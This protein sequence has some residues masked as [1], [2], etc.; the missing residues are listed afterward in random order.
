M[1]KSLAESVLRTLTAFKQSR[2]QVKVLRPH[3]LH[4]LVLPIGNRVRRLQPCK[5][6]STFI[7]ERTWADALVTQPAF[8]G[9]WQLLRA[10]RRATQR[11]G[12]LALVTDLGGNLSMTWLV[13]PD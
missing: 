5:H 4:S 1:C 11:T 9:A 8:S 3:A 2:L 7:E 10:P 6:L 13:P 12:T